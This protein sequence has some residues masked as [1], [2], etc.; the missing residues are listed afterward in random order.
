MRFILRYL[1]AFAAAAVLFGQTPVQFDVASVKP[2]PP[3]NPE[4]VKIGVHI[5]GARVSCSYLSLKD[6]IRIAYR[7]KDYQVSGPEWM[8]SERYEIAATLPPGTKQEQVPDMIKALL[9]DRFHLKV[10][11]EMKEFPVYAL[12]VAKGGLKISQSPADPEGAPAPKAPVNVTG[13]G[14]RNGVSINLGNGAY[15]T[16]SNNKLEGKKLTMASLAETL[17]RFTDRPVID[18]TGA[19]GLYDLSL[20]FTAEDYQAMLIRSAINAGV[21]LPPAARQMMEAASGDSLFTAIQTAGLKLDPRKAPLALVVI[22]HAD[23][24]PSE[25]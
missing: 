22:D 1:P 16:F 25:N 7:V 23:K 15:F 18:M 21:V 13:G 5:D 6:Y 20:D 14:N 12:T 9:A 3:G 19:A 2:S 24:T 17:A 11:D 4:Q 8:S 10:H